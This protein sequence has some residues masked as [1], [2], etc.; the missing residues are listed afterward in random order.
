MIDEHGR[1]Y[2]FGG[3]MPVEELIASHVDALLDRLSVGNVGS[4][5]EIK[6]LMLETI[7][8]VSFQFGQWI[9]AALVEAELEDQPLEEDELDVAADSHDDHIIQQEQEVEEQ[10]DEEQEEKA[11]DDDAKNG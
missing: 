4:V 2:E 10:L 7:N 9:E 3:K 5:I 1:F 8:E 11:Q 6:M